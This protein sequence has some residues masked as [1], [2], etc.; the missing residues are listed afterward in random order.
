VEPVCY[1]IA[2]VGLVL[3]PLLNRLHV[4]SMAVLAFVAFFVA[5]FVAHREFR[6]VETVDGSLF[7]NVLV[8]RLL[9][10]LF[11]AGI[12]SV[13]VIWA[14]NCDYFRGLQFL[15]LFPGISVV[16]AV[17]F[18]SF[19]ASFEAPFWPLVIAGVVVSILG[20]LYDIGFHPQFYTYNHVFGGVLGPIYDEALELRGGLFAF[21]GLTL[22]W[23]G[24]LFAVGYGRY[25][26]PSR[27][28]QRARI[29]LLLASLAIGLS[30]LFS[31]QLGINTPEWY[32]KAQFSGHRTSAHFDLYYD[33]QDVSLRQVEL[34][35]L[36]H[37]YR[38][39]EL[40]DRL[41]VEV[42]D[43]IQSFIY[44]DANMRASLTGARVTSVAPVWLRTPQ[45]H[46]LAEQINS[47]FPH[48][49]VHVFSRQFGLP[50]LRASLAVGLVEGLAV[51]LE[52]AGFGPTPSEKV[53]ASRFFDVQ[54]LQT[55]SDRL[56]S[57]LSPT[58]FWGGRGGVSYETSGAFVG[59][60]IDRYGIN[61]FKE[62]YASGNFARVYG[63]NAG[64]LAMQWSKSLA[65]LTSIH[66]SAAY[67]AARRFGVPSLFER[68]C[69]HWTPPDVRKYRTTLISLSEG[70]I[71]NADRVLEALVNSATVGLLAGAT[72]RR[73]KLSRGDLQTLLDKF[74]SLSV[75]SLSL[76]DEITYA[77]L[78][79]RSGQTVAAVNRYHSLRQRLP[80]YARDAR[81]TVEMRA[82]GAP[83]PELLSI[84]N[85]IEPDSQKVMALDRFVQSRESSL[86][87]TVDLNDTIGDNVA[88]RLDHPVDSRDRVA[89]I[90]EDTDSTTVSS[91]LGVRL[92]GE[93]KIQFDL[94]RYYW[95]Q[96]LNRDSESFTDAAGDAA[97]VIE[98]L[99]QLK[100]NRLTG[101]TERALIYRAAR[102][103]YFAGEYERA[104][105]Y[106]NRLAT[107]ATRAGDSAMVRAVT[108]LQSKI[109]WT[110]RFITQQSFYEN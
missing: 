104:L 1:G 110:Q 87:R 47:V 28:R 84:I 56:A 93:H 94:V 32:L 27:D 79:A 9:W 102:S 70:E 25:A 60:L 48:E 54:D 7:R 2:G 15:F 10:L 62:V 24:L 82:V 85:R 65:A 59:W 61:R 26:L 39:A 98:L 66:R 21:R 105:Q 109:S 90:P 77:D 72:L 18:S 46:V 67:S 6:R 23:A 71:G 69:P 49:L 51:A 89:E 58:E 83:F 107:L 11:P 41:R 37:E 50:I 30:Y 86:T 45:V 57:S 22:L 78:M 103:A 33:N 106:A 8:R 73:I 16:L 68:T 38:Y 97:V 100:A 108:D 29:G 14:P 96:R 63:V 92:D 52:P 80:V 13:A 99:S 74:E 55:F 44:P 20:P 101:E 36:E 19:L 31:A 17:C 91:E 42:P 34:W 88:R 76:T 35:V 81:T 12:L 95:R 75:D 40:S 64:N 3:T 4:E 5:G 43:R 53:V